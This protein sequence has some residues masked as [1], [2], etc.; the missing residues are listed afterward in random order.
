MRIRG[1]RAVIVGTTVVLLLAA[2]LVVLATRPQPGG[3]T[4]AGPVAVVAPGARDVSV[5]RA[6][7]SLAVL[8]EWD[9]ARAA[10]W[11]AGDP[12]ALRRLYTRDSAAGRADV[13][14]L[15]RWA[16]RGLRVEGMAM[17]VLAVELHRRTDRRLV[18]VVTD[19]LVGAEAV[20]PDRQ[21][22]V[23]PR[24]SASR[25]RLDFRRVGGEWRLASV[26]ELAGP[27]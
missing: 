5:V 27:D 2:A 16:A 9:R 10:A 12:G 25:R 17:Q 1:A 21:R 23:L 20:G 13:G 11:A 24:D 22:R 26:V 3:T 7:G 8:R 6:V 18:L 19:R 4:A 14:M 15:R